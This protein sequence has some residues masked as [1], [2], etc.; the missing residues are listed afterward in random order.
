[1]F[2]HAT[3]TSKHEHDC[4]ICQGRW[5][6][7]V[8]WGMEGEPTVMEL[9]QPDSSQEDIVDLY[10]DVCQLWRLPGRV[11]CD[12]EMEACNFQEILDSVK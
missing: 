12:K 10:H 4:A 3:A 11:V 7:S 5:E 1:M 8:E 6:P 2:H 9:I